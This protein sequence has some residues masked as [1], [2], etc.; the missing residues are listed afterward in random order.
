MKSFKVNNPY[1]YNDNK[2]KNYIVMPMK[3]IET[4]NEKIFYLNY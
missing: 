1:K 2:V 4:H 3:D